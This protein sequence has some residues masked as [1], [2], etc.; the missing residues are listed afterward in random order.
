MSLQFK[1][2]ILTL[3]ALVL[4]GCATMSPE[5][6]ASTCQNTDW[7]RYGV[8]DGALGVKTSDRAGD[9]EDCAEVGQPVD[10]AAYQAGRSEGLQSYCTA[11]KGYE[12]GYEGRRYGKVCPPETEP[13]FL[14]GYE[15]GRKERPSYAL[16]P[17]IG[18]G[19]GSGG[20][21]TGIG[22]G[23]GIGGFHRHNCHRNRWYC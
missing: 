23:I 11:E 21:R 20:V 16:Y 15:R 18:I 7:H 9:F 22:I 10:L 12:V 4:A 3:S 5:E 1:V 19:I 8:N 13:D 14:Q 17:S 6:R 2:S